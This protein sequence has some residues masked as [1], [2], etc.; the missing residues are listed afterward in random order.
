MHERAG[1][2]FPQKNRSVGDMPNSEPPS[3]RPK[4]DAKVRMSVRADGKN[5]EP[6]PSPPTWVIIAGCLFGGLT[7]VFFMVLV[8]LSVFGRSVPPDG[9]FPVV[10][11]LA[12]GSALAVSFLGGAAAASGRLPVP[13]VKSN[14]IKF[15]VTG[16]VATLIIVLLL[17]YLLYIRGAE[18]PNESKTVTAPA[19][20]SATA[21]QAGGTLNL[22]VK[23]KVASVP[24]NYRLQAQVVSDE[25]FTDIWS[26]QDIPN[27]QAGDAVFAV[28][29]RAG[30]MGLARLR[31]LDPAG[32]E[33]GTSEVLKFP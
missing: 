18:E 23:F 2:V 11:V 15:S 17:G 3:K 7:L 21:G 19:L 32:H 26:S 9:R 14:P 5:P 24:K 25:G 27:W 6:N 22:R 10:I 28:K 20:F 12:S 29:G 1:F 4:D 31:L 16:G 30:Q 13:L 33:V 8:L